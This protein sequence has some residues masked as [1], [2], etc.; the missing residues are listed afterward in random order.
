M[1]EYS[2]EKEEKDAISNINNNSTIP[3]HTTEGPR[4]SIDSHEEDEY[5][6]DIFSPKGRKS[7]KGQVPFFLFKVKKLG[8]KGITHKTRLLY[9]SPKKICYYQM[10]DKKE[11][12]Q[13]FLD[14]LNS[15]Y[16]VIKNND[17][18]KQIYKK[19]IDAFKALPE[20]EKIEKHSFEKYEINELPLEEAGSF[21]KAPFKVVSNDVKTEQEKSNS[22]NYWIME[23][24]YDF[25]R[26]KIIAESQKYNSNNLDDSEIS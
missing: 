14:L 6:D 22:E 2:Q 26:K 23:A 4:I 13:K 3:I 8:K 18:D 17:Y 25:F 11:K 21:Q 16:K 10:V 7:V 19:M 9:I 24:R 15:L 5:S 1:L 20:E 12:N